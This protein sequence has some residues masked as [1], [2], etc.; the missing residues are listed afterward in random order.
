MISTIQTVVQITSVSAM[1]ECIFCI[2]ETLDAKLFCLRSVAWSPQKFPK[3]ENSSAPTPSNMKSF[4][5]WK[6]SLTQSC[7]VV[8]CELLDFTYLSDIHNTATLGQ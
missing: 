1:S 8:L 7:C 3:L 2:T 6:T 4:K 5:N